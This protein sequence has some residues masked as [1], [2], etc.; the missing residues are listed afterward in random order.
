MEKIW[1]FFDEL[2]ECVYV[3]DI[4]TFD[5]VYMNK[6]ALC[7]YNLNSPDEFE[8][9]K[10]YEVLKNNRMPCAGCNNHRLCEGKFVEWYCYNPVLKRYFHIKD[11]LVTDDNRRLRMEIAIDNSLQE[12]KYRMFLEQQNYEALA[13]E[14]MR[15]ALKADTPDESINIILEYLGKALNGERT[16]IVEKNEGGGDDN[17]Y[18]WVAEGVT[19]EIENLQNL[20]PEICANWYRYFSEGR[21]IA[22]EDIGIIK[23]RDPVQYDILKMQDIHSIAVVPLA[24][25]N[26]TIGFYGIDNPK[27]E[28]LEYTENILRLVGH[29]IVSCL[30]R[31]NILKQL[32]QMSYMDQLTKLGNR[33]GLV[34]YIDNLEADDSIG[35]VYCD[36]TG[37]KKINDTEGHLAGDNLI[38]RAGDCL[39]EVFGEYGL[40]RVGGD[41]MIAVCPG[42]NENELTEKT[43]KLRNIS[44]ENNVVLAIG[45]VWSKT[46]DEN[47]DTILSKSEHLMYEDKRAYYRQNGIDRRR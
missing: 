20:P 10:C 28:S 6:K 4:D 19:P 38:L 31:R 39:R 18:E 14:G 40:F 33:F 37:L 43:E 11:T 16:Y 34:K 25:E 12:Q 7:L 41:E 1:E 15:L 44:A 3:A 17:T 8:G 27:G 24:D 47:I 42:I 35:F 13:N 45:A 30:K 9:K 23:E 36:I 22:I 32:E 5:L 21:K 26:N 2:K 29:F 46:T